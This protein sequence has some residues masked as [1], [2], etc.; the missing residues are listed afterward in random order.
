MSYKPLDSKVEIPQLEHEVQEFWTKTNAYWKRVEIQEK[1]DRPHWSFIDGP[2]TANNPMGV[3]HA[4]GRTYKDLFARYRFMQGYEVR[5]QNGFDCQ[6]LWVEVEVEKELGFKSKLDIEDYGLADFVIKCKQRVLDYSARQTEQSM[7][8]GMWTDWNNPDELRKLSTA[9]KQPMEETTYIGSKG[10]VTGTAE[11]LV[12]QLGMPQMGGSY[13]TFSDE[14]NYMIWKMLKSCHDRG[15]VYLGADAMPWCPRCSTG[16]S[17]HEIVTEGYQEVTHTSVYVLFRL[18]EREGSILIWTTTPWTL[19]SNVAAAI[20][21]ELDYVKIKYRDEIIYLAKGA[22]KLA[23]QDQKNVEVLGELKGADM[24]GWSYDGPFDELPMVKELGVP[25]AHR[26]I[27]WNE[28]GEEE[29]TGIVHIAPGAGK[30][31]HQ[32]GKLYG[33]PSPAPLDEFGVIGDGF[34]WLTGTHVYES[35]EPIFEDLRK[36]EILYRTQKVTHRY[37]VCWRCGSE[38]V[39]RHVSEWFINMGEKLDKDYEEVTEVEK[40]KSLRYQMMDSTYQVNWIPEFGLKRELDWLKNM[41]DWMISKKRY[42]GLALPIWTCECG[43]FDVIGSKEEL[44]ERAIEGWEEFK[45]HAPHRPYIDAVKIKC[46]KCGKTS[47]RIPDV[48]NPWLDAGIVGF[49]TLQYR[50]DRQYWEKWFPAHF[51][52]ESFPGQFRNWFYAMLAE[53]TILE[54]RTPYLTCLGH[55]QVMAEDGREMHKSW[56]NAIW[57]DDAAEEMGA[58]VI[59]W[60]VCAA[61]PETNLLFGFSKAKEVRRLFFMKLLNV[62]NFFYQYASLD[63]W[64]PDQQPEELD[65]LDKWILGKLDETVEKVT[66]SLDSYL[67]MPTCNEIDRFVDI[68]SKWYVRRSRRRFWKTEGDDEKKA[69]YSTLYKCLKTVNQLMAPITPHLSEALYQRMVKPVEPELPESIHHGE[70]PKVDVSVRD[71]NLMEEMDLAL[72]LSSAGRSARNQ[73]VIKLR[74]PLAEVLV[75]APEERVPKIERIVDILREELNVK[76]VTVGTDRSALQGLTVLPVASIL[77]RKYGREFT[78]IG[79]AIKE[80][81]ADDAAKLAAGESVKITVDNKPVEVLPEEVE[82]KSVPQE[83]YSVVEEQDMLVGVYTRL[84]DELKA[85]GLARD[86]VRRIQSLRKDADFD[87]DDHITTYYT[88][89]PEVEVVF[90]EESEYIKLE[91]LSDELVKGNAPDGASVQDFDIDGRSLKLGLVKK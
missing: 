20:H 48:G 10:P 80:L 46:E 71:M 59:R 55:A 24:Q 88:G 78:K 16:I 7:R 70:W 85:E 56:G 86:V 6:G 51:I 5:N 63:G 41:D 91:T 40:D 43:W 2:I 61:K 38:L 75:I 30:E 1:E 8:L 50:Q 4:W 62:Y 45:G 19:T 73:A 53:S 47:S 66:I 89:S 3:H 81:G 25:E 57:F 54:R 14:N 35:A 34:G 13:Y 27:M 87:I 32:L 76:S 83:D 52:T 36:K 77:G 82:L 29:G 44:K 60:I 72:N 28:V 90:D 49:S 69:A 12:G 23:I 39:F 74:Q 67:T 31:D 68:L 37:P 84:S 33:L 15:W 42:Y 79:V 17:Q 65:A 18:R 22:L 11:Y 21:P 26:V 64:T 58:D 9:L